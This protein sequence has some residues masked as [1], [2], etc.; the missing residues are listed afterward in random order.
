MQLCV[1]RTHLA[2]LVL[3]HSVDLRVAIE[4]LPVSQVNS[5]CSCEDLQG[6]SLV[7]R[8]Q[9]TGL[10]HR[11]LV[12]PYKVVGSTLVFVVNRSSHSS[13]NWGQERANLS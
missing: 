10:T 13:K 3:Y 2:I 4:F 7:L 9:D 12:L 11:L 8:A 5:V 6:D 1:V